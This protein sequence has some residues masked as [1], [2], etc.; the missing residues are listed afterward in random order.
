MSTANTPKVA[1][2]LAQIA[3]AL[4][5]EEPT[6]PA[7]QRTMPERVLLTVEEA[8]ERLHVGRTMMWQLIRTGDVESITIGRLRRVPVSAVDAYAQALIARQSRRRNAA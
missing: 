8:A 7:E 5:E 1:A 6:Q 2:L 4:A 3:Q